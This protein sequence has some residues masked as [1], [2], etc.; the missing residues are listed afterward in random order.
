MK[1]AIAS[2]VIPAWFSHEKRASSINETVFPFPVD[3]GTA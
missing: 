2:M 1:Q 3:D